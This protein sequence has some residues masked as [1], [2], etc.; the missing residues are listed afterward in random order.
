[1]FG[2]NFSH[3]NFLWDRVGPV[4]KGSKPMSHARIR[5]FVLGGGGGGGAGPGLTAGKQPYPF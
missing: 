2:R 4:T 5:I 1:M 3:L